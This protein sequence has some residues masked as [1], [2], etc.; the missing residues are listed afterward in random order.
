MTRFPSRLGNT[1]DRT[2]WDLGMSSGWEAT[3]KSLI[4]MCSSSLTMT[5]CLRVLCSHRSVRC[6]SELLYIHTKVMIDDDRRP[7]VQMA[8]VS[9]LFPVGTGNLCGTLLVN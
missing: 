2:R 5:W 3:R 4:R 8:S 6:V 7:I 1:H 9:A